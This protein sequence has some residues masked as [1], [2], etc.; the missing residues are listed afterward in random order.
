MDMLS[1][2]QI[3]S[4]L[5][6]TSLLWVSSI[7]LIMMG[8]VYFIKYRERHDSGR[9]TKF[10]LLYLFTIILNVLEY[11][12]NIVMQT[13]PSYEIFIYKFYILIKFFWNISILFY[14]ISYIRPSKNKIF[15][16]SSII[17]VVMMLLAIACCVFLDIDV[18]LEN[19]G[20]FYVLIGSLNE[21]Y[22]YFALASNSFLLILVLWFHKK[23]PKG[24]CTLSVVTFL[25][26]QPVF[27]IARIGIPEDIQDYFSIT[28]FKITQR[29]RKQFTICGVHSI[30]FVGTV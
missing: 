28:A 2:S 10:F 29:A 12:M 24:F 9:N 13:S 18:V 1:G 23:V 6:A 30:Q 17:K 8:L 4:F 7:V 25:I 26:C 11:I 16:I 19:N 21:V 3:S 15:S 27:R 14:V 20:K 5:S 22:T